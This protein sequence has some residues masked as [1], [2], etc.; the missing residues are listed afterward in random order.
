MM[1][2]NWRILSKRIC[3]L[4]AVIMA[5]SLVGCGKN[6]NGQSEQGVSFNK[7]YV[8][9]VTNIPL[10]LETENNSVYSLRVV[11]DSVYVLLSIYLEN[12]KDVGASG[13]EFRIYQAGIDG[14]MS[15][16]YKVV[17]TTKNDENTN[18]WI[19]SV[20]QSDSRIYGVEERSSETE[21]EN[22]E[23]LYETKMY[24][25]CWDYEGVM[26]WEVPLSGENE[27]DGDSYFYVNHMLCGPNEDIFLLSYNEMRVYDAEGNEKARK[28]LEQENIN[29]VFVDSK[30]NMYLNYY[31]S[32][33][34]KQFA[35]KIDPAAFDLAT[36]EIELSGSMY[37]YYSFMPGT[38]DVDFYV[39][40]QE[41]VSTYSFGDEE[42]KLIMNY[43]DS[44]FSGNSINNM[45]PIDETS[46]VGS[47]YGMEDSAT[48]VALFTKVNP[49]DIV[50]KQ[51]IL[52]GCDY[53]DYNI[54]R[55][56]MEF[57]KENE[58][59][60][61]QVKD[62]SVYNSM[63]DYMAGNTQLNN[64]IL[65]G[66]TPDILQLNANM[67]IDSYMSK[68]LFEDLNPYF[69]K[70]EELNK[71][72]FLV[73]LF[74]AVSVN[75]KL[76]QIFPC[77][78]V[79]TVLGKTKYVGEKIGWNFDDLNAAMEKMPEGCVSFAEM[80][81]ALM[82]NIAISMGKGDYV[83]IETG[84]CSFESQEFM[85][86]LEFINQFPEEI[87]YATL[88][89]DEN[90]YASYQTIYRE[91]RALLMNTGFY[92]YKDYN[93]TVKAQFGEDVTMI[94]FPV[95]EGSGNV[96]M[97][98]MAMTMSS[99][100][101]VKDGAWEFMRYFLTDEFQTSD[102]IWGF[103]VS[104]KALEA[105]EKAAQEKEFF[106]NQET[107][108]KEEYDETRW[109][110]DV[111]VIIDPMTAEEAKEFTGFLKTLDREYNVD[112]ELINIITEEAA[113]YFNGQKSVEEVAKIIQ[114][115]VQIYVNENR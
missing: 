85:Q 76:Y 96:F 88:Y 57:N 55:H 47:Y 75:G 53:I 83:N 50:D 100:S 84:E 18:A 44:D 39:T 87:D 107:G 28:P 72:D 40:N 80:T 62:Y 13:P 77:F 38:G 112:N 79:Q 37:N 104:L 20:A 82:L 4:L 15:S 32:E 67:A 69:E 73:N 61:V 30:G 45:C 6:E 51:V 93:S 7:N 105:L 26:Q 56:I 5:F 63:D 46:F 2:L 94:G 11:G 110:N 36:E 115:R 34:T 29:N 92:R 68:G 54:K 113:P 49:E 101:A 43:I 81:R 1:N 108:E 8:Y 109:V 99:K 89:D 71:E 97:T 74:D 52:Y 60:R 33:F 65:A 35:K 3:L 91:D 17:E 9:S 59:Y 10:N 27:E 98:Q 42:P 16:E 22:G 90:Y 95:K 66:N 78:S 86:L 102:N 58:K 19:Y 23:Y 114:S 48:S 21:Q 64:D 31:N 12:E 70:D 103:P 24:L 111:E 41:G 25:K 14:T 106:I